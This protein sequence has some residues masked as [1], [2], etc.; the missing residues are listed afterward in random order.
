[1]LDYP[2]W[3]YLVVLLVTVGALL[4][5]APNFFGEDPALQVAR[6]DRAAIDEAGRTA[7]EDFLRERQ[8]V[9]SGSYV[10]G[11]RLVVRFADVP[12]QLKA[13]DTVNEGLATT[14]VTALA[15][16]SRAPEIFRWAGLRPMPLG[17]D[18]RG[19]LHLAYQV[20]VNGAVTQLLDSYEQDFRRALGSRGI[21][22]T[23]ITAYAQDGDVVNALRVT[24]PAGA[25]LSAARE[26][27]VASVADLSYNTAGSDDTP[28][29]EAALS[30]AQL[31]QRQDDAVQ[32]NIV[33]LRNRVNELGVAEPVV[34]RQGIDRVV[35]QL[36][37][38]QNSAEVKDILGKVAT[39]EFR[40]TDTQNNPLEAVQRGRAPL[41]SRLYYH[42]D[43]RATLLKREVIATGDQLVDASSTTTDSGPGV[44]VRLDARA[45]EEMLRTTRSNI[46]R[47]MAVVFIE[48]RRESVMV[49]GQRVE[50]DVTDQQ[51]ISEATIQGV[52]SNQFQITG[53]TPNEARELALL[54][55]A[56]QLAAP[57]FIVE[58]RAIGPSLGQASIE[59]GVRSLIIGML[60]L[61]AFMIFYYRVF[62]I[63]ASVVLMT[64]VV[65]LAALLS[66]LGAALSLPGIAGILLT[67]GMAVDANVLIYER[68]REE[69]RNGVS[70]QAAIRVGFDKAFS[71][72]WDSNI[73]TAI[74]GVVLW[75]FGTGAIRG[76]AVVLTLGIATSMFTS[77]MGSRALLTLMYGG[78]RKPERLY[79]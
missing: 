78:K 49:D 55:R 71:A 61:F 64:N 6:K 74:A 44:S 69:L 15:S 62:G 38:V 67:V 40:L 66:M 37:G 23:D 32:Q 79:I 60:A 2:R 45:G 63:V 17:L 43:G 57:L 20:D 48:K 28:Y 35:V 34:Q 33:T 4:F 51:V 58:E 9:F 36:P 46:G 70:P 50:R 53:L 68:I 59:M 42:R 22:F 7:V 8:V 21:A 3:K 72:I 47:P 76:F 19:G 10:D 27:L 26:A 41:G 73:T 24:F 1:M 75:V 18:L 29:I 52:F 65:L 5:A 77:V 30:A 13:R 12:Q 39:L 11:G 54:M 31:R 56:G 25:D 16:A 14:Y